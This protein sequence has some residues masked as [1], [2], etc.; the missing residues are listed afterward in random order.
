MVFIS[1]EQGRE[2]EIKTRRLETL[3]KSIFTNTYSKLIKN[4][5]I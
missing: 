5:T 1:M 4:C 3:V 2:I